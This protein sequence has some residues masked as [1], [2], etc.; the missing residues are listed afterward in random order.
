[1]TNN[2][3]QTK[4][5]LRT[6]DPSINRKVA[7][8][9]AASAIGA[10]AS[11]FLSTFLLNF[12]FLEGISPEDRGTLRTSLSALVTATITLVVGYQT[13]PGERDGV[14]EEEQ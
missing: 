8:A 10:V 6:E 12:P 2:T 13:R 9:S 4:K 7:F 14:V 11:I 5:L 1:M 3:Q